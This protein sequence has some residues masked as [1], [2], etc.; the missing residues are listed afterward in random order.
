MNTAIHAPTKNLYWFR[1][2]LRLQ[3]N[4]AFSAAIEESHDL[5]ALYC[6]PVQTFLRH[7]AAASKI[8][9]ILQQLNGLQQSLEELGIRLWVYT[10]DTFSDEIRCVQALCQK[11][12]FSAVYANREYEWDERC[13]DEKLQQNLSAIGVQSRLFDGHLILSPGQVLTQSQQVFQVF[14]PFKRAWLKV[15]FGTGAWVPDSFKTKK[16]KLWGEQTPIPHQLSEFDSAVDLSAWPAGEVQA[17]QR[18]RN[19][20][21]HKLN[22][23]AE[24]RDQ[25][26]LK[27]SSG[28]SPYLAQGV[29]SPR[30]CIAEAL[31]ASEDADLSSLTPG[32]GIEIWIGEL[33]WRE[34]YKHLVYFHPQV[35]R[36]QAFK[37]ATDRLPWFHDQDL[38]QR[39]CQGQTGF[40][41]VDAGMRQLQQTGWM[42]NRLRMVVAMFLS[43]TLFID[44]RWGE[45]YFMQHL[46]DGDFAANNGGWQWSASTGTDAAPYFRIFNPI[47]QSE[48]F[49]PKGEFIRKYCP[50]LSHLD[51]KTIHMP[52]RR[53][54][55]LGSLDYPAPIV[56]EAVA[57]R[58]TIA[59]FK[60]L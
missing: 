12:G 10:L 19:F 21:Q 20:C 56:D 35:C 5:V 57:H 3:D 30:Q 7:H 9:F 4:P 36:D 53:G 8:Q 27:A 43:K 24:D 22:A 32:S 37:S 33:I 1:S 34:F 39:W 16:F 49:D 42:H 38:F 50:E 59:W 44:W 51:G 18:L 29:L 54:I 2:D 26:A 45:R 46:V 15:A 58:Q 28:L 55:S 40:P 60:A 6:I 52:Y 47:R 11:H 17:L 25:P 13:R 41:L 23:Y 48:R 31:K 14:T